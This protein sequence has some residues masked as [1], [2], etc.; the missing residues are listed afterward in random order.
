MDYRITGLPLAPFAPLLALDD[1]ALAARGITRCTADAPHAFPCRITLEDAL[2]GEELLLL[3]YPH[4]A[5]ATPYAASGPIFIR[6][7]P[8]ATRV[9]IN[10][11]PDQQRRRLLSVRAYDDG[12]S[13]IDA[14]VVEGT[15][16][17]PLIDRFLSDPKVA[18]LHAHN[19][20]RGCYACRITRAADQAWPDSP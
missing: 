20:R 3:S 8:T 19:A 7:C 14:E 15:A 2:P 11:V 9:A 13:M 6:R 17:E 18:Y 10:E 16:L 12:H 5:A 1:E 4:L